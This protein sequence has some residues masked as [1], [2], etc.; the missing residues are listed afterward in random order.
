MIE[1]CSIQKKETEMGRQNRTHVQS[2]VELN[3]TIAEIR[4]K[5]EE[6][7]A[8]RLAER[9]A[10]IAMGLD[11]DSP[12]FCEICKAGVYA[13]PVHGNCLYGGNKIGHTRGHCSA[14]ACY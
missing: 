7:K 11:P 6:A 5:I 9:E 2:K 14:N 8:K 13:G 12:E 1:L 4:L 3:K 10:I